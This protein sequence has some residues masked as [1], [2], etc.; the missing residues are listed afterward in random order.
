MCIRDSFT[1]LANPPLAVEYMRI[2]HKAR[3]LSKASQ[4]FADV[5]QEELNNVLEA[6]PL[7]KR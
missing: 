7:S 5:L 6:D 4:A 2:T 3:P 1:P